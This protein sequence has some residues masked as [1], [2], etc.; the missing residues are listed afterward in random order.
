MVREFWQ[1]NRRNSEEDRYK[2]KIEKDKKIMKSSWE[3]RG[4][5]NARDI[6]RI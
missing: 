5:K 3:K 6:E 2:K 4:R 1:L